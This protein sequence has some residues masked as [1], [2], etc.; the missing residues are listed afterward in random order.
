MGFFVWK[1]NIRRYSQNFIFIVHKVSASENTKGQL[2]ISG[3]ATGTYYLTETRAPDG[4]NQL[5]N[6][7]KIEIVDADGGVDGALDNEPEGSADGYLDITVNN[8][9]GFELPVTGGMGTFM[10]TASG[11]AIMSAAIILIVI[12]RKKKTLS[13]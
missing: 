9:K 3:L 6:P 12:Q 11:V 8:T 10:F 5:R 2:K 13:K 7:V 4:Y 1:K